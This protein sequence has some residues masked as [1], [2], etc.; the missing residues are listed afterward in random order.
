MRNS[1]VL[2]PGDGIGP[3]VV[4]QGARALEAVGAATASPSGSRRPSWVEPP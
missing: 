4:S 1:I 2:I 3:D